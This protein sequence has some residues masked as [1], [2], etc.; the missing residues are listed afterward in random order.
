M[1]ATYLTGH[2]YL[3]DELARHFGGIAENNIARLK[4]SEAMQLL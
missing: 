3:P 1:V 4:R 2:E